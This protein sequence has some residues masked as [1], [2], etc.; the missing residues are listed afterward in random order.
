M[1]TWQEF[2]GTLLG[3]ALAPLFWVLVLAVPLWLV[4]RLAPNAEFWLFRVRVTYAIGYALGR[5]T[6]LLRR[7]QA[8][9]DG[10]DQRWG[11]PTDPRQ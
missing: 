1:S 7:A 4:R 6:R 9:V 8:A 5:L 2:V 3:A 11:R 10:S